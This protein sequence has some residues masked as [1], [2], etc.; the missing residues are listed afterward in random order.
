MIKK[1]KS[2]RKQIMAGYS[3]I[4]LVV[5]LLVVLLL[6]SLFQIRQDYLAVSRNQSNQA[7]DR[8]S[9][10]LNSSHS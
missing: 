4:I 10:R 1:K 8:K 6:A 5:F 2:I 7:R 9:T 3:R